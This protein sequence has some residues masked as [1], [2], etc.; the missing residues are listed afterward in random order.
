GARGGDGR[1][2]AVR[3]PLADDA[4]EAAERGAAAWLLVVGQIVQVA[5]DGGRCF[6]PCDQPPLACGEPRVTGFVAR[7]S[8]CRQRGSSDRIPNPEPRITTSSQESRG[9]RAPVSATSR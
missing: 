9:Q 1:L 2:Q 4:A 8:G 6:Q 7:D 5:L 3:A